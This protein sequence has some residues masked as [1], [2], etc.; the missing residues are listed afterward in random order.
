V[1]SGG[2]IKG[3]LGSVFLSGTNTYTGD[4]YITNGLVRVDAPLA[5]GSAAGLTSVGVTGTLLLNGLTITNETLYLESTG[6]PGYAGLDS[7]TDS[8][9]MGYLYL[10]GNPT[11][12]AQALGGKL[13]LGGNLS[14]DSPGAGFTKTQPGTVLLANTTDNLYDGLTIVNAGS[15]KLATA[16][17]VITIPAGV[18]VNTNAY[19]EGR[20]KI[21][22]GALVVNGGTLSPGNAAPIGGANGTTISAL[23]G[24]FTNIGA[25]TFDVG[26]TNNNNDC[27]IVTNLLLAS[28]YLEVF[29]ARGGATTPGTTFTIISNTGPAAVSGTFVLKPQ[30][31]LITN[32]Y[33]PGV[34]QLSYTGGDGNDVTL[35]RVGF[36]AP[37]AQNLKMTALG[38]GA[39][40]FTATGQAGYLYQLQTSTNLTAWSDLNQ[41]LG[42]VAGALQINRTNTPGEPHRFYRLRSL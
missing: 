13:T 35:T 34:L 1:V 21:I 36:S 7:L 27:L 17:G 19:L 25:M 15:L 30:G 2:W 24:I 26:T 18:Q 40:Q 8:T 12:G 16:P 20:G 5:L 41:L 10:V 23:S 11:I 9:W 39:F 38:N 42:G 33:G 4:T 28:T 37:A 14:Y 22:N 31:T 29:D 3:G 32:G 6:A